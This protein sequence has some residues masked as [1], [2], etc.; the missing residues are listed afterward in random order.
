MNL[1]FATDLFFILMFSIGVYH[2]VNCSARLW[3]VYEHQRAGFDWSLNKNVHYFSVNRRHTELWKHQN[4]PNWKKKN[5]YKTNEGQSFFFLLINQHSTS[6][7]AYITKK[8]PMCSVIFID[9]GYRCIRE[10][11]TVLVYMYLCQYHGLL[12]CNRQSVQVFRD[13]LW[14]YS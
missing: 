9:F 11:S 7:S 5:Q 4:E 6:A 12:K 1:F 14:H 3:M 2:L 13:M 8:N 10:F